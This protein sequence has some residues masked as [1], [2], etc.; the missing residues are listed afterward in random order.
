[1]GGLGGCRRLSISTTNWRSKLSRAQIVRRGWARSAH[2]LGSGGLAV[3]VAE[4]CF[5]N[6]AVGA[7]ISVD[8]ELRTDFALFH[9]APSR[10]LLS[11]D[12]RDLSEVVRA[13]EHSG[14]EALILGET[15]G[16]ELRVR[17]NGKE[18]FRASL[19]EL[20]ARWDTAFPTLLEA[21]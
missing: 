17:L 1:M 3:A 19:G 9:E 2:D 12:P 21:Q 10:V 5:G 7:E 6:P 8:T 4:S 14:V 15:G 11:V 20:H 13:C 16:S 18:A